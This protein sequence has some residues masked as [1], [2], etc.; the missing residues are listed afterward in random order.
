MS[1]EL[2]KS[3]DFAN[4]ISKYNDH[5]VANIV[6]ECLHVMRDYDTITKM[7]ACYNLTERILRLF[8]VCGEKKDLQ[9][10][11]KQFHKDML[12][13]IDEYYE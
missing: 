8:A 10:F 2:E 6:F 1:D 13:Y 3:G 5:L 12:K 7:T 11:V 9:R 4:D